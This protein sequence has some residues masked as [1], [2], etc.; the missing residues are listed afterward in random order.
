MTKHDL[1]IFLRDSL[2]DDWTIRRGRLLLPA[3]VTT[4]ERL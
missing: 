3:W 2:V 1:Q 4:A